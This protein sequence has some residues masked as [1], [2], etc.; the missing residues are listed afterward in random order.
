MG[1]VVAKAHGL[2]SAML[3]NNVDNTDIYRLIYA[4]LFGKTLD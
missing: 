2:N 3:P 1:G 4:T